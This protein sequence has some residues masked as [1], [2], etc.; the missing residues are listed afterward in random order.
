MENSVQNQQ[1]AFDSERF[2]TAQPPLKIIRKKTQNNDRDLCSEILNSEL[3][4]WARKAMAS[5]G[6]G[7]Y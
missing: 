7:D 2:C 6:F 3:E 5:N 1:P 4:V